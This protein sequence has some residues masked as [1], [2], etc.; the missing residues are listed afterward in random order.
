MSLTGSCFSSE[1]APGPLYGTYLGRGLINAQP[2]SDG[3]KLDERKV[4]GRKL[5]VAGCHAP[6]MLDL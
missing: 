3:R 1:S 2:Q 5:V 4:V 6:T